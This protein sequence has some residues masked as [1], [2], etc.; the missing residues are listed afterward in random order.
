MQST[1]SLSQVDIVDFNPKTDRLGVNQ[2]MLAI[3]LRTIKE[4]VL[5]FPKRISK[6]LKKNIE[7]FTI[8]KESIYCST[9]I[10]RHHF[11]Y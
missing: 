6:R 2:G 1:F 9:G 7:I 8:Q 11:P 10:I 4:L 3:A 5:I